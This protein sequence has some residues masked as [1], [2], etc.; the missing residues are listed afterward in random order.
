MM[1]GNRAVIDIKNDS[2]DD[3]KGKFADALKTKNFKKNKELTKA[4][5]GEKKKNK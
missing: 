4:V 2:F 5:F 1:S 3:I